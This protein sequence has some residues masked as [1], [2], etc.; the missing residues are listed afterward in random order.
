M[1]LGV[2]GFSF[3]LTF[4]S[5]F[6]L[7]LWL[8]CEEGVG[9]EWVYRWSIVLTRLSLSLFSDICQTSEDEEKDKER[10][11][12]Y[13]AKQIAKRICGDSYIIHAYLYLHLYLSGSISR[14]LLALGIH[15]DTHRR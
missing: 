13:K 3:R 15:L 9:F 4:L 11:D 12:G 7:F 14:V 5:F 6:L 10:R 1:N 2:D 8:P